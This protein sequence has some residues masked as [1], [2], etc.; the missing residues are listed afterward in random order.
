LNLRPLGPEPALGFADEVAPSRKG[1]DALDISGG[2][3]VPCPPGP[4]PYETEHAPDRAAVG[5]AAARVVLPEQLMTVREVAF[6]LVVCRATVYAM[7][8][9]GELSHVR[10]AGSVRIHPEDL[11]AFLARR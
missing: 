11:D 5:R 4:T 9:R 6:R 3:E 1:S 8:E 2:P 7:V 10:V